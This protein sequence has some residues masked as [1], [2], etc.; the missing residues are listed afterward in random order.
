MWREYGN[1]WGAEIFDPIRRIG[2]RGEHIH[3]YRG[4]LA[5]K[6]IKIEWYARFDGSRSISRR[7]GA[8]K[9]KQ[10]RKRDS[11]FE[12]V[13][14]DS[15]LKMP[16]CLKGRQNEAVV[17]KFAFLDFFRPSSSLLSQVSLC[18]Q[19]ECVFGVLT[20]SDATAL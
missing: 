6:D 9:W 20:I 18:L 8:G 3:C 4:K 11:V 13:A 7:L 19:F 15:Y 17:P 2:F 10:S 12:K 5:S 16:I 14:F 1:W